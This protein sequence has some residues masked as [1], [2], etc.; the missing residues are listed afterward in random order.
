MIAGKILDTYL[1]VYCGS[2]IIAAARPVCCKHPMR[3]RSQFE[4]KAQCPD[5]PGVVLHWDQLLGTRGR[6]VAEWAV[7]KSASA[8]EKQDVV[9]EGDPPLRN[10]ADMLCDKIRAWV[11]RMAPRITEKDGVDYASIEITLL[12]P[13][14]DDDGTLMLEARIEEKCT[15][16]DLDGRV[17]GVKFP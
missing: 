8:V 15:T 5:I 14:G 7:G 4:D 3:E 16:D 17:E 10:L 9:V 12:Q 2:E 11:A 1:C 6:W 13:G